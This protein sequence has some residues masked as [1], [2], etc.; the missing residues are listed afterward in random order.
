MDCSTLE[1]LKAKAE[2]KRVE[3]MQGLSGLPGEG[4]A[5]KEVH[6]S[7]AVRGQSRRIWNELYN[8]IDCSDV[9]IHVL[10]ARDPPGTRCA[11]V[12]K[13]LDKHAPFKYLVY[14]INKVDL[15]PTGVTAR[16]L[17]AFSTKHPVLAYHSNSLTNFYG[18]ENLIGLLRQYSHLKKRQVAVGFVGYP[19]VGKSS[20]INTLRRRVVCSVAPV[21][22]QTKVYQYITLTKKIYLID[23]PGVVPTSTLEEAVLRGAMRVEN[24]EDPEYFFMRVYEK[25]KDAMEKVYGISSVEALDFLE[26]YCRKFGKISRGGVCNLDA[27]SKLLLHD[28]IR[29][30]IPFY[31]APPSVE[32][33]VPCTQ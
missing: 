21:P 10:D 11:S 16:W 29:G 18:Q 26:K 5:A 12:E 3:A 19:N 14:L 31:V 25:A 28:W 2:S 32:E 33:E 9:V 1:E 24:L 30:K 4:S 27:A 7:D 8:V 13:Y 17:K 23:S 15:V 22:G 6:C 20:I